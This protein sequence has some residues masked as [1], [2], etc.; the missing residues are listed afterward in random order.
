MCFH[1]LDRGKHILR[2]VRLD[3]KHDQIRTSI[4]KCSHIAIRP[5]DHE[6]HIQKHLRVPAHRFHDWNTN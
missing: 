3:V 6:V 2:L 4:A 1:V 5:V